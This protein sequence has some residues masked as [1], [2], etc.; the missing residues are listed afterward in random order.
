MLNLKT[1]KS[2]TPHPAIVTHSVD[3]S[4]VCRNRVEDSWTRTI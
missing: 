1:R 2:N 3:G 4:Q